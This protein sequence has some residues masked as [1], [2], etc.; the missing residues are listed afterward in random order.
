VELQSNQQGTALCKIKPYWLLYANE[1]WRPVG[2]ILPIPSNSTGDLARHAESTLA[3]AERTMQVVQAQA[4]QW[5]PSG[6]VADVP[7]YRW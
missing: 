5:T 7:R 4:A 2:L 3:A 6:D 1:V